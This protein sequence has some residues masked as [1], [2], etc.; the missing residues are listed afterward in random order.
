MKPRRLA[1]A[2]TSS[3]EGWYR[4]AWVVIG[5]RVA[6]P[7]RGSPS[8][9]RQ[10]AVW[11]RLGTQLP[12]R[13]GDVSP[14][15]VTDRRGNARFR[16]QTLE[17]ADDRPF[18]APELGV[19]RRVVRDQV[20]VIQSSGHEPREGARIFGTVVDA[21]QHEIFEEDLAARLF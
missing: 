13:R 20:D 15:R 10:D 14:H 2:L 6:P 8:L 19:G 1:S 7:A 4:S 18:G 9:S 17:G 5:R 3:S 11:L 21:G 16:Q 12:A